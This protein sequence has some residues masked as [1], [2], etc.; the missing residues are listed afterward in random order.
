[1][2]KIISTIGP[3]SIDL[4]PQLFQA[5]SNY[6]RDNLSH[7]NAEWH[8][9][10]MK[11][12]QKECPQV[13]VIL[14][15]KG[16]E[17]RIAKSNKKSVKSGSPLII[18]KDIFFTVE[19]IHEYL[20]VQD[21]IIIDAGTIISSVEKIDGDKVHL[22]IQQGGKLE[23]RQHVNIPG[24]QIPMNILQ[25][26]DKSIIKKCSHFPIHAIATSFTRTPEDILEVR[27]FLDETGMKN[28]KIIAKIENKIAIKNLE[29]LIKVSDEI[30]IARGDLAMETN[31][32]TL[33]ETEKKILKTCKKHNQ[34]CI[35][36]TEILKSMITEKHPSRAEI[37]DMTLAL[38]SGASLMFSDET[39]I[40]NHPVKCIEVANT[41]MKY[42]Q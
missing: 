6:F 15:T 20:N 40:G 11:K 10:L 4:M 14:D 25:D 31:W 16:P 13:K 29:K 41:M 32:F 12:I 7:Q 2:K 34:K 8:K 35:V 18:G 33:G 22:H 17:I 24:S 38:Q 39:A 28:T 5:G 19:N 9:N 42:I 3:K 21:I 23:E 36:A 27:K 26:S 37:I 1:M 30:M